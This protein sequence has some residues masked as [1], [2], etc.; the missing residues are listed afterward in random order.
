LH[1]SQTHDHNFLFGTRMTNWLNK[2]DWHVIAMQWLLGICDH[3]SVTTN[4]VYT[5]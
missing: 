1:I 3:S 5:G 4:E 2:I